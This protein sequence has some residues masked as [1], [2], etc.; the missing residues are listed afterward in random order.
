MNL[1]ECIQYVCIY[2]ILQ[3]LE[4]YAGQFQRLPRASERRGLRATSF[5]VTDY[6]KPLF[7]KPGGG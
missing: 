4:R 6:A 2:D 1:F 5:A 3:T 7:R